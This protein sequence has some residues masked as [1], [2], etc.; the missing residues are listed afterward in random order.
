VQKP[1]TF[2]QAAVQAQ[3][4]VFA[5][6]TKRFAAEDAMRQA[7]RQTAAAVKAQQDRITSLA[8]RHYR[9]YARA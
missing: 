2:A 4:A 9:N 8:A 7:E 6:N 1:T 3:L 5:E